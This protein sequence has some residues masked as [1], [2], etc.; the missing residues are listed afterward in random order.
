MDQLRG[1]VRADAA[2][3]GG[4]L[5]GLLLG[6]ALVQDG[7]RVAVLEAEPSPAGP[8]AACASI[9]AGN[10]FSRVLSAGGLEA[11]RHYAAALQSQLN[12]LLAAPL[13][14]VSVMPAYTYARTAAELPALEARRA[15]L[16]QLG[17]PTHTAP[18]AG[19]CPFPVALSL[20]S[21]GAVVDM[22]RWM[23]ALTASIR[24]QGGK[25]YYGSGVMGFDGQRVC[26]AE[27]TLHAPLI[28][29]TTG[30]PLGLRTPRLLALL[31]TRTRAHCAMTPDTPLHSIQHPV[32]AGLTLCP[33]PLE[34]LV[35]MDVGRCGTRQESRYFRQFTDRLTQLLPDW[36]RGDIHF[37]HPVVS[38]DGL[39]VIGAMPGARM[40]FAS[41]YGDCGIL[42]AMHA[43]E[44]LHRR[45]MGRAA[46]EDALYAPERT[47]PPRVMQ[48]TQR[49]L[50][51]LRTEG[52][53]R[54]R[55]PACSHCGCRM[56]YFAPAG[57]WECPCCGSACTMLGQA[58]SGPGMARVQVSPRQRPLD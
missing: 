26:T 27:G 42:G 9:H 53:L 14:Y 37:S 35:T 39:P 5:T 7:V 21:L 49:R 33:T 19:G 23:A 2:I 51:G 13:P 54:A 16:T 8:A 50:L 32:D 18:D 29:L 10:A 28:I 30:K 1:A 56:R 45:L 34:T 40:L 15:L 11:A 31:E 22:H 6:A 20:F 4:G 25:V 36:R 46:P 38:A 52:L 24:R 48:R 17:L 41:G 12:A 43:A 47:I 55:G 44:V 57:R 3:V 58:V